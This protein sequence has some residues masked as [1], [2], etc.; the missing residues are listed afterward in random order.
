MQEPQTNGFDPNSLF[1][2]AR[3]SLKRDSAEL[4]RHLRKG[5]A[6][7]HDF[8]LTAALAVRGLWN[9]SFPL[10]E[11]EV[12]E[13]VEDL[14][15]TTLVTEVAL[16]YAG[17]YRSVLAVLV[18]QDNYERP[19]EAACFTIGEI[20]DL[21]FISRLQEL[22]QGSKYD[23]VRE[24]AIAALGSLGD[25]S[26]LTTI[27]EA[28]SDKVYIRR[29]AVVALSNF[30]GPDVEEALRHACKDRDFQVRAIAEDLLR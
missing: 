7:K 20:K 15:K 24:S 6:T 12:A 25:P 13:L 17:R 10:T 11:H 5:L 23:S 19:L 22:A 28:L 3:S 26:S 4:R 30:E 16:T 21:S 27:L 14:S 18:E 29:R 1:N 9:M 8:E 2:L